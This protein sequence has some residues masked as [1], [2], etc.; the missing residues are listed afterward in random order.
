MV[1]F[2]LFFETH[3]GGGGV[4][5]TAYNRPPALVQVAPV[6]AEFEAQSLVYVNSPYSGSMTHHVYSDACARALPIDELVPGLGTMT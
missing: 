6:Y 4:P 5:L 3:S 1:R 2:S